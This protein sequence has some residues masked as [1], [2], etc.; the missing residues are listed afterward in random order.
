M[1][2]VET[3]CS[4]VPEAAADLAALGRLY[5]GK[6]YHELTLALE[7][8]VN[9]PGH[10]G[11]GRLLLDLEQHFLSKFEGKLNQLRYALIFGAIVRASVE[12][13]GTLSGPEGIAKNQAVANSIGPARF[14]A[15]HRAWFT[16]ARRLAPTNP[17]LHIFTENLT[18]SMVA[19]N[20]TMARVYAFLELPPLPSN[21]DMSKVPLEWPCDIRTDPSCSMEKYGAGGPHGQDA[22]SVL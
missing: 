6:L 4:L 20:H 19:C 2:W 16:L 14:A 7:T 21:C 8:F 13:G 15:Q 17:L 9:D 5:E 10:Q 11:R 12:A 22:S 3:T 1:D 18:A